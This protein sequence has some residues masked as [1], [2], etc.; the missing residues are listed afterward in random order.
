MINK[1]AVEEMEIELP[2]YES[3]KKLVAITRLAKR[4]QELLRQLAEKR[5]TYINGILM[6]YAV[7]E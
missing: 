1:K 7:K 5:K 3:Q 2:T 4:E 6:Q